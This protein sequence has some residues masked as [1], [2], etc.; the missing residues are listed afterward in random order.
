MKRLALLASLLLFPSL[1]AAQ[2]LQGG[3]QVTVSVPQGE[4]SDRLSGAIGFGLSGQ[5]LY[6]IPATPLLVGGE[7]G[8]VVYGQETIREPFGGGALGRI[9]VDV[10]TTNNIGL[11]HLVLRLQ[12]PSGA[13]R[14]YADG[15]VGLSYFYTESRIES[16]HRDRPEL[17]S[18]T[19]YDDF[20]FSY[21]FAGGLQASLMH[22]RNDR[23]R[24]FEV[25][26]DAR[27]RYLAGGVAEY[28]KRGSIRQ[29]NG[30]DLIYDV[31][32]SRTDLLLP[33]VGLTFRF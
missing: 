11:G 28:L 21:G 29:D 8:G 16:V 15:L 9:E 10:I 26:L 13:V 7:V 24:P 5:L 22:G 12:P 23:G 27:L 14:P 25:V 2:Q 4:F 1:A 30:G 19:N 18:S 31:E 33:Q 6:S 20:A 3:L 32:R 17:V